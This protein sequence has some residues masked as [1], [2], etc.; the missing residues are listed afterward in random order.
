MRAFRFKEAVELFFETALQRLH[1]KIQ[2]SCNT[3]EN[4]EFS[5]SHRTSLLM[6]P[7]RCKLC[8]KENAAL[9]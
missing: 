9:Y 4:H 7:A 6:K 1:Q 8:E 3:R 5:E 2:A